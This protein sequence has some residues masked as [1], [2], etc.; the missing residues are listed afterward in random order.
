ME[1]GKF[2]NERL[3]IKHKEQFNTPFSDFYRLNWFTDA[4]PNA[5]FHAKGITL[6]EGK[7]LLY[8]KVPKIYKYYIFIDD[9]ID[10][11]STDNTPVAEKIK[12]ILNMYNPLHGTFYR[13]IGAK[14]G[15][16]H[17]TDIIK[18]HSLE[19]REAWP[20]FG[21]DLDC[22]IY[23]WSYIRCIL[24][25]RYHGCYKCLT[26]A[27]Y[28]CYKLYPHKQLMFDGIR[29]AN[30]RQG[31]HIE[32]LSLSQ[33]NNGNEVTRLFLKDLIP[34]PLNINAHFILNNTHMVPKLNLQIYKNNVSKD[35]VI[36]TKEDM[37]KIC[38]W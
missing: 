23:H 6:S 27:Q 24:P 5:H 31:N 29:L 11:T 18:K 32:E 1:Q 34:S 7:N 30:T 37:K 16:W 13:K 28:I 2:I 3:T 38:T 9:D 15:A 33:A 26:Y 20:V 12:E 19:Q 21:F 14:W 8:E 25:I 17:V 10:F 22:D 35:E 4:D 36:F